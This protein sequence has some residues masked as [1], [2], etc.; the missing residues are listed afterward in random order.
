[1]LTSYYV[2]IIFADPD[3]INLRDHS[4]Y[5]VMVLRIFAWLCC[6]Y[7]VVRVKY[8][9]FRAGKY[10]DSYWNWL[11]AVTYGS[12]LASIPF[13]FIGGATSPARNVLLALIGV[14]LWINLLQYM[15]LH[16]KTGLLI[17]IMERM[18]SDVRQFLVLY[19]VFLLGFSGA[20]H[21]IL[22]EFGDYKT[23]LDT[24]VTVLLMPFEN[25]T[26]DSYS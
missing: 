6:L 3:W 4:D 1:M 21:L 10:F 15:W 20:L 13:E 18:I 25:I 24:F 12:V 23:F 19:S 5:A 8:S 22:N 16:K 2:T 7:L 26:Y 9:E 14:A 17:A 11:N